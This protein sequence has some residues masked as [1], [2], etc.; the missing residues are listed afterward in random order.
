M[1]DQLDSGAGQPGKS[2]RLNKHIADSGLCSR[3]KADELIQSG[4]VEVNGNVV[5]EPG[6]RVRAETDTIRVNGKPLP[7][8][9][10]V[11]LLL[12][13]PVGVL[14]AR[15]N[16]NSREKDRRTIYDLLPEPLHS[17]DPAGRLD[18]KSSGA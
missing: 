7:I 18:R 2:S 10:L 5:T 11:Y 6:Q 1:P 17:V 9:Q 15:L 4:Q 12:H 14:T 8:I 16:E 13:K 3:R